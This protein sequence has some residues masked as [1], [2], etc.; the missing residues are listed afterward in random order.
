MLSFFTAGYQDETPPSFIAKLNAARVNLL[1]DVRQNPFSFKMGFNRSQLEVVCGQSGINYVHIKEL[2]TPIPLRN[3][4]KET[5]DYKQ[6]FSRYNGILNEYE[7]LIEDLVSLSTKNK[8]CILCFEKSHLMCHR[9]VI[10]N[11]VLEI[12]GNMLSVCHL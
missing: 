12:S 4:L 5:G 11:K 3:F 8:V 6:F 2:G 10:A 1:V 9:Q 7:D